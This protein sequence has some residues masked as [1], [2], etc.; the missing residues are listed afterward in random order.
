MSCE[1]LVRVD[2]TPVSNVRFPRV[3]ATRRVLVVPYD[4]Q[5]PQAFA[6]A[7]QEVRE[8][9]GAKLLEV[10][11]IGS[12]SIPGMHAKPVVV[13][14]V[15]DLNGDGA[16]QMER[17]SV[18]RCAPYVV[19]GLQISTRVTKQ[20]RSIGSRYHESATSSRRA[21][22]AASFCGASVRFRT[23]AHADPV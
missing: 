5:W 9:L 8:A 13:A 4:P 17:R 21:F 23:S 2:G 22:A 1:D 19:L 15:A 18:T 3:S 7:A 6:R 10:H 16:E 11:H 14:D 12:T 20:H